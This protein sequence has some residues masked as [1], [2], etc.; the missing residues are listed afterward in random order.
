M[1]RRY[2]HNVHHCT[3]NSSDH[4]PDIQVACQPACLQST[5]LLPVSGTVARSVS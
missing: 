4:D 1:A 5:S 3:P 2:N